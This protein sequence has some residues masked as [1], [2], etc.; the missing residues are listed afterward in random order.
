MSAPYQVF[1]SKDV[2]VTTRRHIAY[3]T[4]LLFGVLFLTLGG[5]LL[6]A[7][8][9]RYPT[10]WS[11]VIGAAGLV[12]GSYFG[13]RVFRLSHVVWLVKLFENR[14]EGF[15]YARRKMVM[16]WSAVRRVDFQHDHSILLTGENGTT[17]RVP[18]TFDEFPAL[19]HAVFAK[20]NPTAVS[21]RING[22]GLDELSVRT[23]FP[24]AEGDEPAA[25]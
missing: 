3:H 16:P 12:S 23:L 14:I 4:G 7:G 22:R 21:I 13:L 17:I 20:L 11:L 15:D 18:A 1:D 9:A 19:A 25:Y 2:R 8:R 10:W 6:V 24:E 5:I